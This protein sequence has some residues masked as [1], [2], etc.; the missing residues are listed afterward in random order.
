MNASGMIIINPPWS[1]AATLKTVLPWLAKTLGE[2][3]A[4]SFRVETLVAEK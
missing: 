3:T 2:N 4:G 1:L